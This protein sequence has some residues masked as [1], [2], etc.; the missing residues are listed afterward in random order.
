[1]PSGGDESDPGVGFHRAY[2]V[3]QAARVQQVVRAQQ[4]D[5]G[6]AAQADCCPPVLGLEECR[7]VG[8]HPYAGVAEGSGDAAGGV[9]AGV[10]QH[11]ELEIAVGLVEHAADGLGE[12]LLAVVDGDAHGHV[13]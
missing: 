2:L 9:G 1:V 7:R 5:Q 4:F 10:V 6:G 3:L 13:R 12:E 8:L 11:D